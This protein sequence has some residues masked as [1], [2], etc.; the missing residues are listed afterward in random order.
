[1]VLDLYCRKAERK[2][3]GKKKKRGWPWPRGER[4]EG[5]GKRRARDKNERGENLKERE[6]GPSSPFYS[7]L[8]YLAIAG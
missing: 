8:G 4:G 6:E 7:G 1:M 3:E 2:R 5:R